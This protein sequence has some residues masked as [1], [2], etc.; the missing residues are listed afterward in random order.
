MFEFFQG[1]A[2]LG[3][4]PTIV[5]FFASTKILGERGDGRVQSGESFVPCPSIIILMYALMCAKVVDAMG[6]GQG[7][8]NEDKERMLVWEVNSGLVLLY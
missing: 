2:Y 1:A 4:L 5:I 3:R 8:N 6:R 7:R